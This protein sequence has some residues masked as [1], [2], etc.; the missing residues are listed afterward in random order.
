MDAVERRLGDA[1]EEA[2][3]EG[4][5]RGL[6]HLDVPVAHGE[7][8]DAGG[9][10]EAGEVPRA[11]GALDEVV[12]EGLDVDEHE[13]VERPV[14]S[15]GDEEGVDHRDDEREDEG[16]V[17]VHPRESGAEAVAEPHA[18]RTDEEGGDGGHDG[19]RDEGD[20]DHLEILGDDPLEALVDEGEDG[21]HDERDEDVA[22][23]FV[24]LEGQAEDAGRAALGVEQLVR[25]AGGVGEAF[26]VREGEE[27]R[28]E[29]RAHDGRA[30]PGVDLELLRRVVGDHDRE[31]V[32]DGAPQ[33]VDEDPGGGFVGGAEVD[34]FEGVEDGGEGDDEGGAEEHSED[35]A[36]GVGEVFE[37]VVEPGEPAA[38]LRAGLRLHLRI[39]EDRSGPHGG[40]LLH[41]VVDAGDSAA[42]DDLVAAP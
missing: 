7:E 15:E 27:F 4:A 16:G 41:R 6:A 5:G 1:A 14:E 19:H 2:R 9:R 32:E 24:E 26:G 29:E 18:H 39:G 10:A 3:R 36:E 22:A 42:D 17:A 35:R 37:E 40:Q 31:E 30:E 34:E 38:R 8:E 28:R 13:R 25:H 23:V 12:A 20:E 11:H 21:D 33:G